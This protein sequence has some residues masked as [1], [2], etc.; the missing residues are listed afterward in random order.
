ML[1]QACCCCTLQVK[2]RSVSQVVTGQTTEIFRRHP[3]RDPE[4]R[5]FSLL[6][7]DDEGGSRSLDLTCADAQ[8]FELWHTGLCALVHRLRSLGM[9]VGPAAA[10]VATLGGS[11]VGGASPLE[12]AQALE[13]ARAQQVRQGAGA[14]AA[15]GSGA[16]SAAVCLSPAPLLN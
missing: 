11:G 3:L 6:Y 13:Q 16:F 12:V 7:T 14:G 9:P 4:A 2:L 8:Q 1:H 10:G 15:T 5:C